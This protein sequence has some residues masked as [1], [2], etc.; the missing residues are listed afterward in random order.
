LQVL[1]SPSS[2]SS[3]QR[4]VSDNTSTDST[5]GVVSTRPKSLKNHSSNASSNGG[6]HPQQYVP[7]ASVAATGSHNSSPKDHTPRSGFVSNDH[8]QHRNSFRN[9]NGGPHQRGD[10]SHHH[11]YGNRRQDWNNNR[12][13]SSRDTNVSPRVVPRFIRPPP[14]PNSTQFF[15]PSPMPPFGGHIGFHGMVF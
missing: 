10:G 12:S 2:S 13:F 4:E 3:L 9:R 11:N 5:N 1:G 14:P 6:H 8:P 15:H 7:Q